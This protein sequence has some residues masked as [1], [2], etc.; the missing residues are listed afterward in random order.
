MNFAHVR[1]QKYVQILNTKKS[2]KNSIFFL[3]KMVTEQ[4]ADRRLLGKIIPSRFE[5]FII[6]PS[7]LG[8]CPGIPGTINHPSPDPSPS[9]S[10]GQAALQLVDILEWKKLLRYVATC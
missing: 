6:W 7:Q 2:R 10:G 1:W 4:N 9:P 3:A 5:R 8:A